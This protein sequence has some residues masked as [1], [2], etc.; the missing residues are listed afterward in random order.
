MFKPQ[1]GDYNSYFQRY[2]DMVHREPILEMRRSMHIMHA[3]LTTVT[4]EQANYRYAEGKWSVKEVLMHI[5][6]VERVFLFRALCASRKDQQILQSFEDQ[7][8]INNCDAGSRSMESLLAEHEAVRVASIRFFEGLSEEML[9]RKA[10]MA[11]G[12]FITPRAV[13]FVIVGHEMHHQNV[14]QERYVGKINP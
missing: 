14:L 11:N 2:I 3:L 5:I 10:T 13:A 8:Y 12:S 4:E 1:P 7:E 9:D 6:D